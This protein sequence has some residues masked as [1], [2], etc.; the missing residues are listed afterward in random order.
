MYTTTI[1]YWRCETGPK[2]G[3]VHAWL[4]RGKVTQKYYCT[5]CGITVTK[6]ELKEHTDA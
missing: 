5:A 1:N 4:Y 6:A 2:T 3:D